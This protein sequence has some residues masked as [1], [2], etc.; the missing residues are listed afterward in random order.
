MLRVA[1]FLHAFRRFPRTATTETEVHFPVAAERVPASLIRPAGAGPLPGWILLHGITVPGREH[2]V[3]RRFAHSLAA[4]GATVLIPEIPAWRQLRPAPEA[5]DA[6]VAAAAAHLRERGDVREQGLHL[7]GFSFG[8]TQ[9]LMSAAKPGIREMVRSVVSFGGYCD[10][11][12]TLHSMFTGEHEWEGVTRRLVPD[13]YGRWIVTGNYLTAVPEFAQM[14]ELGRA[15]LALAAESGRVGAYADESV[16]D[17]SKREL[18]ESLPMEQR[19]IWDV[20]AP[21]AGVL[22]PREE[23][24]ELARKLFQATMAMDPGLDPRPLLSRLDQRVVLA[25]GHADRLI[26]F[27]ETLRLRAAL[28]SRVEATH[29]V[30]R[31]FAHSR[32]AEPLG[33]LQLPREFARY[34]SLLDDVLRP[35]GARSP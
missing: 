15:A 32:E 23:A 6:T 31:L 14:E 30:T 9:A 12:R 26:P 16:Y 3:L 24:V 21:P 25:H 18:R 19:E 20:I 2:P 35:A 10:L 17:A 5:A 8:G 22:P 28:P 34:L 33:V 29:S 7:V 4:S 13:P 11:E 27:T 1:R